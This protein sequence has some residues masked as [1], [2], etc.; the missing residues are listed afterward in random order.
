M[1]VEEKPAEAIE[2]VEV[3]K[4]RPKKEANMFPA[5]AKKE[6][7]CRTF[8]IEIKDGKC[9]SPKK[10]ALVCALCRFNKSKKR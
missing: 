10:E 8:G 9:T 1:E 4:P 7:S 5:L 6:G 2:V 3:E